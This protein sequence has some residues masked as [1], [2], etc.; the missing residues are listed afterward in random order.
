MDKFYLAFLE[1]TTRSKLSYFVTQATFMVVFFC[2]LFTFGWV[3]IPAWVVISLVFYWLS[4]RNIKQVRYF[5][6]RVFGDL[7]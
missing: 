3:V 1:I 6:S 7:L 5:T 4:R 2:L